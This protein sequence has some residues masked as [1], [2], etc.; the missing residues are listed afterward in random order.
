MLD[1][2]AAN[3][4]RRKRGEDGE[5]S[6]VDVEEV[7][8]PIPISVKKAKQMKKEKRKGKGKASD[9]AD[10]ELVD[11]SRVDEPEPDPEKYERKK[12]KEEAKA[13]KAKAKKWRKAQEAA[14][15]KDSKDAA[16][17][18]HA[19][20]EDDEAVQGEGIDRIEIDG[21][22]EPRVDLLSTATPS[23]SRSPAFD[24]SA[25]HSGSS[26]ISSIAPPTATEDSQA[27]KPLKEESQ[28]EPKEPK[29]TPEEVKARFVAR[30]EAMKRA[31]NADGLNG[32]PARNRQELMEA[33]RQKEEQR[34][35][36]KKELRHR[37]KEEERQ[38]RNET[39]ARGSPLLSGSPLNAPSSPANNFSFSRVNFADGQHATADLNAI[40]DPKTKPKGP[41]DPRTALLAAQK[42]QS[43]LNSLDESKKADMTEKDSWLNARKRA[44]GE[45]IR[46]DTSLLKKTL[47]RKE[48]QKKKSSKEWNE[49]LDGVKKSQD[50]K[51]KKRE[52]NLQKR[53]EEKG[54][55]GGKSGA[56]KGKGDGKGKARPGFEGSFRAKAPSGGAEGGRRRW[57]APAAFGGIPAA[58][59]TR[60]SR[61]RGYRDACDSRVLWAISWSTSVIAWL[62]ATDSDALDELQLTVM[63]WADEF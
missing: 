5:V 29:P 43:R 58:L 28:E 61:P 39:L 25:N 50:M 37:A 57:R 59:R 20:D 1:E 15:E 4:R 36:H 31:R 44:H 8:K 56:R 16:A 10:G 24:T 26:S 62:S 45:R 38:K 6:E 54:K 30:I 60:P 12:T 55:K 47:K 35:A 21:L 7:E 9:R 42:K 19:K 33:R 27:E 14:L 46:D 63:T 22:D 41:S 32:A 17:G 53:K 3:A 52:A 48:K 2:Q 51:Q 23:T 34:K 13:A 18:A 40:I 49:R 11:I